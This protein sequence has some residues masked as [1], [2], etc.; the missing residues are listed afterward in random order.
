MDLDVPKLKCACELERD[1]HVITL[2]P[3][4]K[5]LQDASKQLYVCTF[6]KP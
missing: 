4:L 1:V 5:P 3:L 6:N 2:A